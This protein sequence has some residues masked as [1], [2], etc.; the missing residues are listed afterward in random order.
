RR[1]GLMTDFATADELQDTFM[2]E[3]LGRS[4][5]WVGPLRERFPDAVVHAANSAATLRDPATHFAMVRRGVALYGMDPFGE[6]PLAR[7]LEPALALLTPVMAVKDAAPG[8]S[9][10]YGRRFV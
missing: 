3:Q 6:D 9:A 7:E 4:R 5:Q 2:D 10:G 8:E 1:G